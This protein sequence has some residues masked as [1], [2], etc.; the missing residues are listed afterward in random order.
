MTQIINL[1]R[2]IHVL[3]IRLLDQVS[4]KK[5]DLAQTPFFNIYTRVIFMFVESGCI[6][7]N[8]EF[9]VP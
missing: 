1:I 5:V 7:T 6:S 8:L 3:V 4:V 9:A 2:F